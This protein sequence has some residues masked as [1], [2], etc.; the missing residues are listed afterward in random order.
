M[1]QSPTRSAPKVLLIIERYR[2]SPAPDQQT[3]RS[4]INSIH[5]VTTHNTLFYLIMLATALSI[6]PK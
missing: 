5:L 1:Q 3:W 6:A 2:C 4:G